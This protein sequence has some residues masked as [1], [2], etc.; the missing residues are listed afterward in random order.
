MHAAIAGTHPWDSTRIG[1]RPVSALRNW[2][3]LHVQGG[4]LCQSRGFEG[5]VDGG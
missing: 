3:R 5:T 1:R 4:T 2:G